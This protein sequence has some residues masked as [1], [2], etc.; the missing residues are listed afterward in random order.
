MI[1][2]FTCYHWQLVF[3]VFLL[4]PV[5]QATGTIEAR[6]CVVAYNILS[7]ETIV[8]YCCCNNLYPAVSYP[9]SGVA[10]AMDRVDPCNL[11]RLTNIFLICSFSSII[12]G[13][14]NLLP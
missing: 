2:L 6:F 13:I 7:P 14:V 12:L 5:F 3:T 10:F 8:S 9:L 1:A 4:S 11:E